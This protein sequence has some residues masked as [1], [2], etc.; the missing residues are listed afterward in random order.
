MRIL[1]TTRKIFLEEAERFGE[2][3]ENRLKHTQIKDFCN[4]VTSDN[5][6]G[7]GPT[8]ALIKK[9]HTQNDV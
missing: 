2:S 5:W 3:N 8:N 6:D 9:E 1:L 4:G 7:K